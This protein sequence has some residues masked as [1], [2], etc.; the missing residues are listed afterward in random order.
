MVVFCFWM[1]W[2]IL[3]IFWI[4]I[5]VSFI[6]GLFKRR[7]F[8]V[9]MRVCFMVSI[10]C[11]FFERVAVFWFFCFLRWGKCEKIFFKLVWFFL[12]F[13]FKKVFILRFFIIVKLGKTWCFFGICERLFV[14]IFWVGIFWIFWFKNLIF[15]EFGL[16]KLDKVWRMVVLFVLLVLI[17]EII[18]FLFILKFI[19]WIVW[20]IL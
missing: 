9:D 8:G 4:K 12:W 15:F 19:L 7:S 18:F 11:F 20:I 14:M 2:M 3:K 16:I 10:C 17:R 6:D 13:F 5:G 1:F